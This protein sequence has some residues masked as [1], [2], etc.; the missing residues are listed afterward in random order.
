MI[1]R[2]ARVLLY[3]ERRTVTPVPGTRLAVLC[4]WLRAAAA[5]YQGRGQGKHTPHHSKI[6]RFRA[7]R[8]GFASQ[9]MRPAHRR[10]ALYGLG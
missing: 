2:A 3:G 6:P 8:P 9:T 5:R 10:V 4:A 1:H 7:V